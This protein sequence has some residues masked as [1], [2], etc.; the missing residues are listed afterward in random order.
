MIVAITF[1]IYGNFVTLSWNYVT[2]ILTLGIG[3]LLATH[4]AIPIIKRAK[5]SETNTRN[6]RKLLYNP[7]V[8][9]TLLSEGSPVSLPPDDLGIV[10]GNPNAINEIIKVCNPYCGPCSKAHPVLE[11]ILEKSENI[12]LRIIFTASGKDDD[13][14]TYPVSH[15]L[16]IAENEDSKT[17]KE[18]LNDWYLP[19]FKDYDQ[20]A[21]K[22]P[23]SEPLKKQ[24]EK[25]YAMS[26]WCDRM[27]IRATPT[28]FINGREMP[29]AYR[30]DELGR[31]L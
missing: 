11:S 4:Y 25:I 5:D 26:D 14:M 1:F 21:K 13:V 10:I 6:W 7:D 9:N 3:F 15:L 20:F 17:I 31:V 18:A 27:K 2:N 16:A 12:K 29:Q 30:I 8:F 22:Y 28:I 24:R 23:I 19:D